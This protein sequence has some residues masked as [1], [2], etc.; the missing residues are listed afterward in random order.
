M[1]DKLLDA[2]QIYAA[3]HRL[4]LAERLGSGMNGDV[5]VSQSTVT[6]V[7][8]TCERATG[9]ALLWSAVTRHRFLQGDASPVPA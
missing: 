1:K 4:T 3:S 7:F 2:A 6:A 5:W 8:A 9:S